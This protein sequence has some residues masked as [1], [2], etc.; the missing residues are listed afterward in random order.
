[1]PSM[2]WIGSDRRIVEIS[3]DTPACKD[4]P[5]SKC[6]QFGG[7]MDALFVIELAG[8]QAAKHGLKLGDRLVF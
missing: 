5:A 1:M 3:P 2:G 6:P 7:H 8:G 4:G